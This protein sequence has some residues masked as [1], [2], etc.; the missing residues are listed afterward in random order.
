M[1]K[2]KVR[3]TITFLLCRQKSKTIAASILVRGMHNCP[4]FKTHM[5]EDS[6]G[7]YSH[8]VVGVRGAVHWSKPNVS[9][10]AWRSP[11]STVFHLQLSVELSCWPR[12]VLPAPVSHSFPL[13]SISMFMQLH[14]ELVWKLPSDSLLWSG[15]LSI[16]T[17]PVQELQGSML[18]VLVLSPTHC[19][20]TYQGE[21]LETGGWFLFT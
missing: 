14:R 7:C 12:N 8:T 13:V 9:S 1:E 3:N 21:R 16:C 15:F 18:C 20:W 4:K 17:S 6:S 5:G 19:L 2:K 10:R 11:L